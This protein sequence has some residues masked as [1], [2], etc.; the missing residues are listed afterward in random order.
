MTP[1]ILDFIQK[2]VKHNKIL[3]NIISTNSIKQ[4]KNNLLK[5]TKSNVKKK[6]TPDYG[7]E[8][9]MEEIMYLNP[10][11]INLIKK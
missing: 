8:N 11:E 3:T 4:S 2:S 7:V 9:Y 1:Y 6:N 5:M 10:K